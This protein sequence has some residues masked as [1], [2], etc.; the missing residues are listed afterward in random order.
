MVDLDINSIRAVLELQQ[1]VSDYCFDLDDTQ[2]L[3]AH[4]FFD[5]AC[6]VQIGAIAL[7]GIEEVIE[8]YEDLAHIVQAQEPGAVR[9][10]RHAF[11]NFRC[12]IGDNGTATLDFLIANYSANGRPPVSCGTA[13]T[14]ISD[15]RLRCRRDADARWRILEFTGSPVFMGDDPVQ[16]KLLIGET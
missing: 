4:T 13:P 2:G 15:C 1:L 10:T 11:T 14:V 12:A 3:N 6:V 16:N 7:H 9:T 5:E 8:F